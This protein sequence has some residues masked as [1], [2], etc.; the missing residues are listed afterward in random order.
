MASRAPAQRD[1]SGAPIEAII[2]RELGANPEIRS[3][4]S[5]YATMLAEYRAGS[6]GEKFLQ[7]ILD[8]AVGQHRANG[9]PNTQFVTFSDGSANFL[10]DTTDDRSV[11]VWGVSQTVA[12]GTRDNAYHA[13][14]PRAGD[15]L[16]KGLPGATPRA[17]ARAAPIISGRP[18]G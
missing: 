11:L 3:G 10:F 13:G 16:D 8:H 9:R 17:G 12:A 18:P 6:C 7:A 5:A 1:W 15:G 2:D 4:N 14:Y